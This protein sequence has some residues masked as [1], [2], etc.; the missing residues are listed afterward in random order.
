MTNFRESTF[1]KVLLSP[2]SLPYGRP[3]QSVP[4]SAPGLGTSMSVIF[5]GCAEAVAYSSGV[6]PAASC[7]SPHDFAGIEKMHNTDQPKYCA[8]H[9]S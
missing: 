3:L 2:G 9:G 5:D 1:G 6:L 7:Q 8:L 4:L